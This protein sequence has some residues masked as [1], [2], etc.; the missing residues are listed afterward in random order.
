[1]FLLYGLPC[2]SIMAL[3]EA[4]LADAREQARYLA[5]RNGGRTAA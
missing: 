2:W 1:M 5:G 4:S 3:Q